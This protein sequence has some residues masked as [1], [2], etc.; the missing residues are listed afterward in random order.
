MIRSAFDPSRTEPDCRSLYLGEMEKIQKTLGK[1]GRILVRYSGTEPLLRIMIE[2]PDLNEI[3][4]YA[5]SLAQMVQRA[6]L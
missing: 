4:G 2:G 3:R 6:G 1:M 5:R